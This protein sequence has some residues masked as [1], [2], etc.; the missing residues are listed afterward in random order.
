[1]SARILLVTGS[2]V[3]W[4]HEYRLGDGADILREAGI[5]AR[6]WRDGSKR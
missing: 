5:D 4:D 2:R 3:L 6:N 1:M